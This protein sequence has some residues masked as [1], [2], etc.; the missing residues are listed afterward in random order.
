MKL[1]WSN[2][3]WDDYLHW[4]R[5]DS[6]V[7][8]RLNALIKAIEQSPFKGPGKPEPLKHSLSGWWSRRITGEH[9]LVYRVSGKP[10]EQVLELV[11]CRF[12]Y[13]E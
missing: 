13:R 4:Q 6:K 5:N 1:V 2:E 11:Q 8:V 7:F 10:G 3:A 9:R 12:H